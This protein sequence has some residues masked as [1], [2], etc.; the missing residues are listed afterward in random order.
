M[1]VKHRSKHIKLTSPRGEPPA[2]D[3]LAWPKGRTLAE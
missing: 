3:E 2:P 1:G